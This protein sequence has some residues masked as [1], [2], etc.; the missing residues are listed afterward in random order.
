MEYC[1]C[2]HKIFE[3]KDICFTDIILLEQCVIFT[4]LMTHLT[5]Y[6]TYDQKTT[7]SLIANNR[8]THDTI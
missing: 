6:K 7:Q 1:T 2:L 4:S 5:A 8:P 3:S